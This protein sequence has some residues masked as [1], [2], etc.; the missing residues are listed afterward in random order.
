MLPKSVQ[1]AVQFPKNSI[2]STISKNGMVLSTSFYWRRP[3]IL[4][5]EHVIGI[6]HGQTKILLKGLEE[7]VHSDVI[8]KDGIQILRNSRFH[9]CII[10][11]GLVTHIAYLPLLGDVKTIKMIILWSAI[12]AA[13][14]CAQFA[15]AE[16]GTH[17]G[18]K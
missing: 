1:S 6:A 18:D 7:Q 4:K 13:L 16:H 10:F 2:Q 14:V 9:K 8:V 17:A 5:F 3:S 11:W 15:V 12:P